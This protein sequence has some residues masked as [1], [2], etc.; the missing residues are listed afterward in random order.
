MDLP[1]IIYKK[2]EPMAFISLNRPEIK[3]AFTH[4]MVQSLLSALQDAKTDPDIK[5]IV[6]RGEGEVFSAGGNIKDMAEGKLISWDMKRFLW[7]HVQ[8]VPLLLEDVDK[9]VIASIDGPAFGAG[10]DLSLACDLRIAS[11]RATFCSAF[12]RIG[13]APGD[14]GAY[15]LPRLVGLTRA[16]DILMTGRVIETEEAFRIG[17]VNKVVP[18]ESLQEET[19]NYAM[20]FARWPQDS[21]RVIKR[22]VYDGLRSDLRG[23]LDYISSQLA[24][25]SQTGE[26]QDAVS[27]LAAGSKNTL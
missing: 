20:E 27:K 12:V 4:N 24:L 7:E 15:F 25:L 22:A 8:R 17:L 5:V 1:D 21:L 18:T 10:F 16:L 23:H 13:L 14:G 6:L 9:P 2:S 11:E 3:N 26:H 19:E